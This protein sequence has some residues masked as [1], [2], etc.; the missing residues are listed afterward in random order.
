MGVLRRQPDGEW[1]LIVGDPN[2]REGDARAIRRAGK[3]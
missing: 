1:K 2:R 3:R